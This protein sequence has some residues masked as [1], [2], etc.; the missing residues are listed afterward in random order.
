M[1]ASINFCINIAFGDELF[2]TDF[3]MEPITYLNK[4]KINLLVFVRN[5]VLLF[6]I[7]SH[8]MLAIYRC[9][10]IAIVVLR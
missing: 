4:K 9:W 5:L 10:T 3:D 6:S 2:D 1:S 8:F 7:E